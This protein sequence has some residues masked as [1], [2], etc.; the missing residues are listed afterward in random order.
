MIVR[1]T[2][3]KYLIKT[4]MLVLISS[5]TLNS[6]FAA[7][8]SESSNM[9][10][11]V[12]SKE[13][14][15]IKSSEGKFET[16]RSMEP[17]L[18]VALKVPESINKAAG[19]VSVI[20]EEE[21]KEFGANSLVDLLNRVTSIYVLGTY[22]YP[23]NIVSI[24][25]D[26]TDQYNNRVQ[27]TID[28]RP[29]RESVFLGDN[30]VIY[31]MFPLSAIKQIEILRGPSGVMYGASAFTGVINIVTKGY[32]GKDEFMV[33]S[34][35]GSFNRAQ[36][37]LR[38]SNKI[39]SQLEL[40]ADASYA[41]DPGWKFNA[42]DKAGVYRSVNMAQENAL[43]VSARAKYDIFTTTF[44]YG[45]NTQGTMGNT[46]EWA[47]DRHGSIK[48]INLK[49]L[50]GTAF[51]QMT[52]RSYSE[53][54]FADFTLAK[55]LTDLWKS[56]VS[57]TFSHYDF[58]FKYV[59][60]LQKSRTSSGFDYI[61]NWTN[62]LMPSNEFKIAFGLQLWKRSGL[63]EEEAFDKIGVSKPLDIYSSKAPRNFNPFKFIPN[64]VENFYTTYLLSTF[65]PYE[66]LKLVAGVRLNKAPSIKLDVVPELSG[67][68]SLNKEY[69]VKLIYS[70]SFRSPSISER[71][72]Q[73][74]NAYGD[75]N[76]QPERIRALQAQLNYGTN[77]FR[78]SLTAF[79]LTGSSLIKRK[80]VSG[81]AYTRIYANVGDSKVSG[82]ELDG[83]YIFG[84]L[85]ANYSLSFTRQIVENKY[86]LYGMPTFLAK[87]G[88]GYNFQNGINVGLY[89]QYVGA[90][91]IINKSQKYNPSAGAYHWVTLNA[92]FELD[93]WLP[94]GG[95]RPENK[96]IL[97]VYAQN[98]LNK[99]VYFNE[100]VVEMKDINTI[101]GRP[102][103]SIYGTLSYQF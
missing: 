89:D 69:T 73:S 95:K 20:T 29:V 91:P 72:R 92:R 71:F 61:Y 16:T 57:F 101:P 11:T 88:L 7:E 34:T 4:K 50:M 52:Y 62:T 75:P 102:G 32:T 40:T 36:H 66:P 8:A 86:D 67:V 23:D 74:S 18:S 76:L 55:Q 97:N 94:V 46:T 49:G 60:A 14:I 64:T 10:M 85:L 31:T 77:N 48:P 68:Y 54:V 2:I 15:E 47:P 59:E 28:G 37:Y 87:F 43:G 13:S 33:G 51:S 44:F 81:K 39:G 25:G 58:Y 17:E 63:G 80:D 83:R 84:H 79:F 100:Y 78:S 3:L 5:I 42:I 6:T 19:I 70:G 24:R 65:Q 27:I 26:A 38:L 35:Y 98:L 93:R 90:S 45:R 21:I 56:S 9:E 22:A 103:A 99:S 96:M 82:V 41:F 1:K 30:R 53:K 12:Q